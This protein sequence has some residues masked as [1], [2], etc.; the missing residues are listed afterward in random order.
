M[1]LAFALCCLLTAVV[2]PGSPSL[3]GDAPLAATDRPAR[4]RPVEW[5]RTIPIQ[6]ESTGVAV[7]GTLRHLVHLG[8]IHFERDPA[9]HRLTATVQAGLTCSDNVEHEISAAVLDENGELLGTARITCRV[10]TLILGRV[11]TTSRKLE[12]DFGTSLDYPRVTRFALS[13]NKARIVNPST[14]A[15]NK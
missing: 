8:S 13:V 3:A 14:T 11:V 9:S 7:D 4:I 12:L 2:L 5:N 15:G 1:K 10:E 6:M